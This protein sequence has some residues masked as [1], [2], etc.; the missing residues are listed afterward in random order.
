MAQ[1]LAIVGFLVLLVGGIW[2]MWRPPS[3]HNVGRN[4]SASAGGDGHYGDSGGHGGGGS[5]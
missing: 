2:L 3:R 5:H 1:A 4:D